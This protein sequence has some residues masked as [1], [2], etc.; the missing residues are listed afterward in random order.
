VGDGRCPPDLRG[1]ALLQ[2]GPA[3]SPFLPCPR[4]EIARGRLICPA[5]LPAPAAPRRSRTLA[6]RPEA[7]PSRARADRGRFILRNVHHARLHRP[8]Q[9]APPPP[10][11]LTPLAVPT[12]PTVSFHLLTFPPTHPRTMLTWVWLWA[13]VV[14]AVLLEGFMRAVESAVRP[15][16]AHLPRQQHP[17]GSAHRQTNARAEKANWCP[18]KRPN[19][20]ADKQT[21]YLSVRH[22][23]QD[24]DS[25]ARRSAENYAKVAP[26]GRPAH[27]R[28]SVS[29]QTSERRR[30]SVAFDL[31][32]F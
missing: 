32:C 19:A 30:K 29:G 4:R 23:R 8:P 7:G 31:W 11:P 28:V 24:T 20:C 18:D 14:V 15:V 27:P 2:S 25:A 13:Q 6:A 1:R 10:H 16:R 12:R 26:R 5:P 9:R 21:N 3:P 22:R 17:R